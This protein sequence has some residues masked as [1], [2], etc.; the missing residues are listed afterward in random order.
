MSPGKTSEIDPQQLSAE[1]E[2]H[3]FVSDTFDVHAVAQPH[4]AQEVGASLL[5][6]SRPN[7]LQD[8]LSG[9]QLKDDALDA[10]AMEEQGEER[11]RRT[12]SNDHNRRPIRG[13]H[14][15]GHR[16]NVRYLNFDRRNFV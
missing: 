5:D 7:P 4:Q 2:V 16:T 11:S 10:G 6:D 3:A 13:R 15:F 14:A 1:G 9:P 8:V 12:T